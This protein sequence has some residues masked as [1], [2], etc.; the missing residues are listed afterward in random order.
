M[1]HPPAVYLREDR[2]AGGINEWVATLFSPENIDETVALLAG[3]QD[4]PDPTEAAAARFR[5]RIEAAESAMARL[6]RAIE[7]G[8]DPDALTVQYNAA[9]AE[10]RAAE[11]GLN[12][13]EPSEWLTAEEHRERMAD[14]P[15]ALPACG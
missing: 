4:G 15:S 2:L 3:A 13:L 8:W 11:A 9:V 7:A 14:G 6:Q 5:Q 10:K 12:G 1:D